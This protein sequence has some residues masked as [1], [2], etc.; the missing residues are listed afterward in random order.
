[1]SNREGDSDDEQDSS[2][3]KDDVAN[4]GIVYRLSRGSL[5]KLDGGMLRYEELA[6]K[7]S[8]KMSKA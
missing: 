6:V 2:S 3:D 5:K 7:A 8:A 4:P 1:M